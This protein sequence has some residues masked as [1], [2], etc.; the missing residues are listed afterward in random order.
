MFIINKRLLTPKCIGYD[1]FRLHAL[2][3]F[4]LL[5]VIIDDKLDFKAFA[6]Q[7][8]LTINRKLYSI[9]RLFYLPL[10]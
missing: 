2:A 1:G 7:T 6:A 10:L 4:Q 9:S 8:C 5:E 3:Q